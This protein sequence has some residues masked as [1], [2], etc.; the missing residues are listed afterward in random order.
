M[1]LSMT[2]VVQG[3][4]AC[5]ALAAGTAHAGFILVND[6]PTA[7][8]YS[9]NVALNNDFRVN[10]A[11]A[12][13]TT[14]TL[15]ASLATDSA[16]SIAFFYYGKEAGYNNQFLAN[17]AAIS[18]TTG[19]TPT[20]QNY[21]ANPIAIPGSMAVGG[22][23]FDFRFCSITSG[24]CVTNAQNDSL[25]YSSSQSIAMSI[26]DN[27]NSAWLFWD[28][29]GAGPDDNHDDMLIRAV[30]TPI[31]VPEPQTLG[32]LG[33]GLLGIWFTMRRRERSSLTPR[34]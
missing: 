6:D 5:L 19:S 22:G 14:Y 11:G 31:R 4:A 10:L 30:F 18:Y 3:L 17:G 28:D 8:I 27:G 33:A 23:L 26:L 12:G 15:G 16:G 2:G 24:G 21:F 34:A 7:P 9:P 1:K 25:F 32:L 20:L 29:S 13:V